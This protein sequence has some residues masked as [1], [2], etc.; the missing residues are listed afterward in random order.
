MG[1]MGHNGTAAE[2]T[3][4][5]ALEAIAAVAATLIPHPR[6]AADFRW[7][8]GVRAAIDRLAAELDGGAR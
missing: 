7:N 4:S 2:G 8:D 1:H 3:A 6:Y 5:T